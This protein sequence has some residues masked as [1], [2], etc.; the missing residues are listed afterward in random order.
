MIRSQS[1][2][3]G[4]TTYPA[5]PHLVL[6]V[7]VADFER[8]CGADHGLHRR[9]DV[10][11]DQLGEAALVFVRVAGAMD[12]AHLFDE[13]ALA[14]LS[15]PCI[16]RRRGQRSGLKGQFL[17]CLSCST[18]GSLD[19]AFA[20]RPFH[21]V[22]AVA[23]D[24]LTHTLEKVNKVHSSVISIHQWKRRFIRVSSY[25]FRQN[26]SCSK[27]NGLYRDVQLTVLIN[28]LSSQRK[29]SRCEVKSP[30]CHSLGPLQLDL[31]LYKNH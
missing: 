9:V 29:Q 7:L 21:G 6:L 3:Y 17:S 25:R 11:V 12:D 13:C 26:I 2:T 23:K 5:P 30:D 18:T 15:R 20:R 16:K 28:W 1:I 27:S 8:L 31:V 14:A 4:T 24:L 19:I 10:L 22:C